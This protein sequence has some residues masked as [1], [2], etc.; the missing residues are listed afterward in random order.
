MMIDN[1]KY[2]NELLNHC[3]VMKKWITENNNIIDAN[4]SICSEFVRIF[5]KVYDNIGLKD[6]KYFCLYFPYYPRSNSFTLIYDE[7]EIIEMIT[8]KLKSEYFPDFFEKIFI[9]HRE[10][11]KRYVDLLIRLLHSMG[12]RV[13]VEGEDKLVFCSSHPA[14]NLK[15]SEENKTTIKK[16]L[17]SDKNVFC[18]MLYSD[19]YFKSQACLNEM[20]AIWALNRRYQEVLLPGFK[21]NEIAGLL[22][23]EP[24]W[25]KLDNIYKLNDFKNQIVTMFSLDKPDEN[26]WESEKNEFL[27]RIK[28]IDNYESH[29]R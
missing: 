28:E 20:G 4:T 26:F 21:S 2:V 12:I 27:N 23:N 13:P 7:V 16:E 29:A 15:P 1:L 25:F 17:L 18:I 6:T 10:N 3:N 8:K 9:S 19:D 22:K 5:D 14:Y 24:T 11:D